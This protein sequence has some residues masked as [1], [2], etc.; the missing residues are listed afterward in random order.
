V[1]AATKLVLD[2]VDFGADYI[3][4]DIGWES[5]TRCS[6][7]QKLPIKDWPSLSSSP[8]RAKY[9]SHSLCVRWEAA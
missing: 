9:Q 3:P 7:M 6:D 5:Q 8:I 2:R 1:L 4:G